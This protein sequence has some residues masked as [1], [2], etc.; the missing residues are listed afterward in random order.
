MFLLDLVPPPP[1]NAFTA[2]TTMVPA[3]ISDTNLEWMLIGLLLLIIVFLLTF[4]GG[5]K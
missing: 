4:S 2:V 3:T 5:R 1:P